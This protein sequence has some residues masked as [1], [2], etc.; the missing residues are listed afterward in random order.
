MNGIFELKRAL[1]Q[2]TEIWDVNIVLGYLRAAAPLTSLS[3]KQLTVNLTMSLCLTTG[4]C[5]QTLHKFDVNYIQEM[6][7][8]YRITICEKLTQS[9]PG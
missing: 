5:G 9:K 2:Y 4:Q 7:D 8:C 6:N 3:L 1:P